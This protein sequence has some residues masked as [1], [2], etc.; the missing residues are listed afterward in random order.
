VY[1]YI[2]IYMLLFQT[3]AQTIFLN[4]FTIC[5]SGYR[6]FVACPFVDEETNGNYLFA[7]GLNGLTCTLAHNAEPDSTQ[8][9]YSWA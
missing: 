1:I 4:P 5:S 9:N 3:E 8:W 6:M 2:Y 7:N